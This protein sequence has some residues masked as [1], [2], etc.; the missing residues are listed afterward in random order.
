MKEEKIKKLENEEISRLVNG[1]NVNNTKQST[2]AK[3][4]TLPKFEM[5]KR[6]IGVVRRRRKIS[7]ENARELRKILVKKGY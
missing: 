2:L 7:E 3:F 1:V 5:K 6:Y 4:K